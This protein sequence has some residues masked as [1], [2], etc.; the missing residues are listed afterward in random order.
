MSMEFSRKEDW[1]G[2][3]F[4]SPGDLPN[5]GTEPSAPILQMDFLPPEPKGILSTE[6]FRYLL[7][8][9]DIALWNRYL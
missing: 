7:G 2:L 3:P 8:I 4:P 9:F 5:P 6:Q 1:S